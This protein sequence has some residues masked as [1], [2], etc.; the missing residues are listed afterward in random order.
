MS[1]QDFIAQVHAAAKALCAQG[2]RPGDRVTICMPNT[3]QAIIL[4]YA[5]NRMGA[6]ANMI[7]P[8]SGE[9][10]IVHYINDSHSVLCLTLRQFYPKFAR[11]RDRLTLKTLLICDVTDGLAGVKKLLY[12]LTVKQK[13]SL[14]KNAGILLWRDFISTG[15]RW[16]G[17]Y[18]H[19]AAS[20]D[21]AAILSP[22]APPAPAREFSLSNL[23]FNALALQ[24][25]TAGDCLHP[26]HTMLSIMPV[27]HGF[28]LGVCIHTV[29]Y[30]GGTAILIPSLMPR[31]TANCW[32]STSPTTLPACP[33]C[34]RR[35]C[36]W[37]T[38]RS[39]T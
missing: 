26:G 36:A 28:G 27:F 31:A 29:L 38:P 30:W 37:R 23:N 21:V 19:H 10:E 6:V 11:I 33:P 14:P 5:V 39:W 9:E 16:K 34:S 17:A 12:P 32:A 8:L 2:V 15:K 7:H 3:P 4:F 25:G 18:I 35:F 24:T 20:G 22:A 1:F 13:V